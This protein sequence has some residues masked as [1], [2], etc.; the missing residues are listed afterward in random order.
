MIGP[1]SR[2]AKAVFEVIALD[3]QLPLRQADLLHG[4]AVHREPD[5]RGEGDL[6]L[7]IQARLVDGL[8]GAG[9]ETAQAQPAA[10]LQLR[11]AIQSQS[12]VGNAADTGR[13]N[14]GNIFSSASGNGSASSSM[15]HIQSIPVA[16]ARF[17][18]S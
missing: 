14:A 8:V 4:T 15:I 17:T 7:S 18:P 5:E 2:Q 12:Q 3:E 6:H 10:M 1:R 13:E 9:G 11:P 16:M